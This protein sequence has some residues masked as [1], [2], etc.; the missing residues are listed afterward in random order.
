MFAVS[1]PP[2][3]WTSQ[4]VVDVSKSNGPLTRRESQNEG[5]WHPDG[6]KSVVCVYQR[7]E[8]LGWEGCKG[9]NEAMRST[10]CG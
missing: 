4:A 1:L 10:V 2:Y 9:E 3:R 6:Y 7:T 5:E 8:A